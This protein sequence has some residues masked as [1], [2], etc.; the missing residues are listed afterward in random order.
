M[1]KI[2]KQRVQSKDGC[3]GRLASRGEDNEAV[4]RVFL[5]DLCHKFVKNS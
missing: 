1:A 2:K 4:L 3:C 5:E